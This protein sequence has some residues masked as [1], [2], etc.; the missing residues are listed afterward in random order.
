MGFL[1]GVED[2]TG[3]DLRDCEYF[4]GTSAGSIAAAR[5]LGGRRPRRPSDTATAP[6][7]TVG[8]ADTQDDDQ[9]EERARSG[10]CGPCGRPA[11]RRMVAG[12]GVASRPGRAL[13]GSP[14]W[15]SAQ[16]RSPGLV[17][18]PRIAA[19]TISRHAL[20]VTALAST[21]DCAS[22]AW[23][24][25]VANGWCS[26][27]PERPPRLFRR[28]SRRP[29]GALV[30]RTG[31]DRRPRIRRRG[32]AERHQPRRRARRPRHP[33]ALP[34]S[35]CRTQR[36]AHARRGGTAVG[37]LGGVGRGTRTASPR[38]DRADGCAGYRIIGRDGER[39]HGP[40]ADA[41]ASWV[42]ATRRGC[43]RARTSVGSNRLGDQARPALLRQ[44]DRHG[45]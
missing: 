40:R 28:P 21:A 26:G 36:L 4:V 11:G 2:A 8:V 5:L 29:G 37:A 41:P 1:A 22:P 16:G 35:D 38:R 30:V 9:L 17:S 19:W 6:K 32:G 44:R 10:P 20:R 33:C 25:P 14:R 12:G 45:P 42:R 39:L 31:G 23:T 3:F 18:R 34:E 7:S 27:P 43:A 15:D 24:E 13:A